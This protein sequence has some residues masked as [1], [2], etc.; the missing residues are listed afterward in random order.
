ML[1]V[2]KGMLFGNKQSIEANEI[3]NS[4][5][6]QISGDVNNYGYND[7]NSLTEV[8][9]NKLISRMVSF[10]IDNLCTL[11]LK[12]K[13][14]ELKQELN[15]AFS[16]G[17]SKLSD[18][19]KEKIYFLR[20]CQSLHDSEIE[21]CQVALDF[22]SGN[23]RDEALWLKNN[24]D[25]PFE[26]DINDH[27]RH[28]PEIQILIIDRLFSVGNFK[29]I[30]DI[31]NRLILTGEDKIALTE[32]F[33]TQ[34]KYYCG[35]AMFN[36]GSFNDSFEIF[37]DLKK[38]TS[39]EKF[40][41]FFN[42]VK[43]QKAN[44]NCVDERNETELVQAKQELDT[45][46]NKYPDLAK[47]NEE[48]ISY[49]KLLTYFNLGR[50]KVCYLDNIKEIFQGFSQKIKELDLIKFY[51]GLCLELREE[52]E[53]A[54]SCYLS[55]EWQK[56]PNTSIRLLLCYVRMKDYNNIVLKYD[57]LQESAITLQHKGVLLLAYYYKND[58]SY[59]EKLQ[60]ALKTVNKS[61][62]DLFHVA[63]YV[64]D[65]ETFEEYIVKTINEMLDL[66]VSFNGV[67]N[68]ILSGYIYMFLHFRKMNFLMKTLDEIA[69]LSILSNEITYDIFYFFNEMLKQMNESDGLDTQPEIKTIERISDRFIKENVAKNLFLVIKIK[70][71]EKSRKYYSMLKYSK[72]L[73]E[74][75]PEPNVA[76][77]IIALS[78]QQKIVD[79]DYYAPYLKAVYDSDVPGHFM[80][81]AFALKVLGKVGEADYYAYKALYYL[82]GLDDY[83]IYGEIFRYFLQNDE[84]KSTDLNLKQASG[85]TVLSLMQVDSDNK[86][87]LLICLDSEADLNIDD[88]K[89]MDVKHVNRRDS[90]YS[91]LVTSSIGQILNI[92]GKRY[93]VCE[94]VDRNVFAFRYVMRKID[95]HR[96]Q[97]DKYIWPITG[98]SIEDTIDQIKK[99]LSKS[100]KRNEYL[101]NLYNFK[102]NSIGIPI[103]WFIDGQ[104]DRYIDA[105]MYLLY[106]EDLAYYAGEATCED[107]IEKVYVIS[108]ST[109]CILAMKDWLNILEP[110]LDR[111]VCPESYIS[112]FQ[113]LL[114]DERKKQNDSHGLIAL[115]NDNLTFLNYDEKVPEILE[116][117]V[118]EC[119]K[120]KIVKV[121]EDEHIN[122]EIID[123]CLKA[124]I[125]VADMKTNVVQ[126]DALIVSSKLDAKYIC[127]DLFFRRLAT[128]KGIKN[129][130]FSSMLRILG[131]LETSVPIII[132][133]SKTNYLI[134]PFLFRND[135]E[136][137]KILLNLTSGK[138]K[139]EYYN[140]IKEQF[141][142]NK[143]F[144]SKAK[145]NCNI[146]D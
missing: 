82:N 22:L 142:L 76:A 98:N 53:Q 75:E 37:K 64:F 20:F 92:K 84:R 105:I 21:N 38:L 69:S 143:S 19:D 141:E 93:K 66:G 97:F 79:A 85:N 88:N 8:G 48:L 61:F 9:G 139:K 73:F 133:L 134:M 71:L 24:W 41:F 26:I 70:C 95:D 109:L 124:E 46:E 107:T 23:Y 127:D 126:M 65:E 125:M 89:S 104:Y 112:F 131:D 120:F 12:M 29:K 128:Q 28:L 50:I 100:K 118:E 87:S 31:Y 47:V 102:N 146:S 83:N 49:L 116:R 4:T 77:N 17:L 7:V 63:N 81:A 40:D 51:F 80:R 90:L 123:G 6:F 106:S 62:E 18:S 136:A 129:T 34:L 137:R 132:E 33:C 35:L 3:K 103:D 72:E 130:N 78:L 1:D 108:I 2:I 99:I 91:K 14:Q 122:F 25:R 111:I 110:I 119:K 101:L 13:I 144:F 114:D 11:L 45:V 140:H 117:I 44:V 10:N 57:E 16:Y 39:E 115:N 30:I 36:T 135:E 55:S 59:H 58:A 32:I 43:V 74:I 54:I 96:E 60:D 94:I 138:I 145:T 56:N 5:I 68:Y 52:F 86:D 113:N 67:E 27:I 15:I 121:E 42:I